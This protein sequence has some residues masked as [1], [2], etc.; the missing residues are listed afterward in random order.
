MPAKRTRTV[1]V[2]VTPAG[3]RMLRQIEKRAAAFAAAEAQL[4]ESVEQARD[5]FVPWRL[6]ALAL[7]VSPQ[8][9]QQRFSKPPR[10]RLV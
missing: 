2:E 1:T 7:G 10:G 5:A 9:A 4:W 8:A 6:I 3:D